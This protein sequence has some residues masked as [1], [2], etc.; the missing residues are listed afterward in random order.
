MML[1]LLHWVPAESAYRLQKLLSTYPTDLRI[2]R[3]RKTKLG[4]YRLPPQGQRHRITINAMEDKEEFLFTLLHELAHL[5]A[6]QEFGR[7]IQPHGREW[8]LQYRT[9]LLDFIDVLGNHP[10]FPFEVTKLPARMNL[11]EIPQEDDDQLRVHHIHPGEVFIFN[12]K[13]KMKMLKKLRKYYVCLDLG[14]G[15]KY[16]VHPMGSVSRV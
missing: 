14:N 6:F 15:K 10:R 4:D 7:K 5:Y 12:G 9:F 8:K 16:R 2:V 3:P 1:D 11:T 13:R